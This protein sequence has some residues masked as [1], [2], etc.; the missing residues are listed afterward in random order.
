MPKDIGER[1]LLLVENP[2][3]NRAASMREEESSQ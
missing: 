1:A 2:Q 3:E